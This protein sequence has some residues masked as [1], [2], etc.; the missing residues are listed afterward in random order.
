MP[1]SSK[2][3]IGRTHAR[4]RRKGRY[5]H[6]Y[7]RT[8]SLPL[9]LTCG[10]IIGG[11]GWVEPDSGWL[12]RLMFRLMVNYPLALINVTVGPFLFCERTAFERVGGFDESLYAAEEFSLA[13]RLK[14]EGRKTHKQWKIIK[15]H[16]G[17]KII[18]S[19]RKFSKFGGFEMVVQNAN[20]L[21]NPHKR[22]RQKDHC[23]FWYES[24]KKNNQNK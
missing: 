7:F 17:H 24:R 2:R 8:Y 16:T 21:W 12:S 6:R 18:T 5:F 22:L 10:S 20:L 23:A 13:A 15:Y 1:E 4:E 19:S 3:R 11:G 14:K 9:F